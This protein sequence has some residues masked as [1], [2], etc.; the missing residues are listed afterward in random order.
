MAFTVTVSID[1]EFETPASKDAVFDVVVNEFF[2]S[3]Q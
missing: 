2:V 3:V 1:Q